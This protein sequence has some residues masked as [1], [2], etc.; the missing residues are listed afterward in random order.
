MIF[1]VNLLK[2]LGK[3]GEK[4]KT[5]SMILIVGILFVCMPVSASA[6]TLSVKV[7]VAG[8]TSLGPHKLLQCRGYKVSDPKKFDPWFGDN[9][10]VRVDSGTSLDFGTLTTRLF[11]SSGKETTG[12]GC[13]YGRDFF[14]VYFYPDAWG[15]KGYEIT[16]NGN[17]MDPDLQKAV[18]FT[19]V[20][21]P[22]DKWDF[23]GD[24]D[25]NDTD[26]GE[27]GPL[28]GFE[29]SWNPEIN[30]DK[31]AHGSNLKILKA[32]TKHIVRAQVGIPPYPKEGEPRPSGWDAIDLSKAAGTYEGQIVITLT[33]WQ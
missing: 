21:A 17:F 5:L 22:E 26:E 23:N 18:V 7:N 30:K 6:L 11:D 8:G 2:I 1:C 14:V 25:F 3:G 16:A 20:Y 31:L 32:K 28:T 13:F 29:P 15:G 33:E 9:C 27:Q 24:G 10:P 12:A 19:P 4:M